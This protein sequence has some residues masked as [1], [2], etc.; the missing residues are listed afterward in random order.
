VEFQPGPNQI[1]AIVVDHRGI[2]G[3]E[4]DDGALN[5]R[6]PVTL[7]TQQDVLARF[8]PGDDGIDALVQVSEDAAIDA[9]ELEIGPVVSDFTQI[10][11]EWEAERHGSPVYQTKQ[12]CLLHDGLGSKTVRLAARIARGRPI[13][14]LE[15]VK[16]QQPGKAE[17]GNY[18]R[19]ENADEKPSHLFPL[20]R[21]IAAILGEPRS[22]RMHVGDQKSR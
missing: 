10:S 14:L 2:E 22:C 21:R 17:E 19:Y 6:Q 8:D 18:R 20:D 12:G 11:A 15:L 7:R 1:F 13:P 16:R 4:F 9:G 5:F 3:I